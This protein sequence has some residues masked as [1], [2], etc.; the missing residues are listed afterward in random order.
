MR[1]SHLFCFFSISL[2]F[3]HLL[4]ALR[5]RSLRFPSPRLCR[6][7]VFLI[8]TNVSLTQVQ[9]A[10]IMKF[11]VKLFDCS[12][13]CNVLGMEPPVHLSLA[14]WIRQK[15]GRAMQCVLFDQINAPMLIEKF[16]LVNLHVLQMP[17]VITYNHIR[18]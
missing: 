4:V 15:D 2:F 6:V 14:R 18:S 12:D 10:L 13:G 3:L 7:A 5:L 17:A 1:P 9:C 8:Q 16:I 11:M